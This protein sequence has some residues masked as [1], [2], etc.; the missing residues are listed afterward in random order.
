V[1]SLGRIYSCGYSGAQ[2]V[3]G[4]NS[5]TNL[6]TPRLMTESDGTTPLTGV[7]SMAV[8]TA[9]APIGAVTSGGKLLR[10]G[11]GTDGAHGN[12]NTTAMAWPDYLETA[13]GSGVDRTDI[14]QAVV[15]GASVSSTR[16]VMWIRTTAG[17]IEVSG[18]RFL[19]NGDGAALSSGASNTF[20]L[21][22]G[23]IAAL[24]VSALYAGGGDG[25]V[26][27]AVTSGGVP[28]I[29]GYMSGNGL[30]GTTNLNVFSAMT[31]LPTGFSGAFTRAV[32]A[33]G[34]SYVAVILEATISG[35]KALA[36]I[37]YDVYYNTA[38][39]TAGVA[40]ASQTWGLVRGVRATI[41]AWQVFGTAQEYGLAVLLTDGELR[42]AGPSDQGQSGVTWGQVTAIDTLQPVRLGLPRVLKPPT[43]PGVYSSIT[44][45][46]YNDEVTNQ[47]STWRYVA[48]TA[49][50]GNAPPT[51]PTESN[52]YWQLIARKGDAG[53]ANIVFDF[54]G[55]T[56]VLAPGMKCRIP[57]S[58]DATIL[59]A[60]LVSDAVGSIVLDV[61]KDTYANYPP[62]VA[63][64]ITAAAK[65]TLSS[66]QKTTDSSLMGWTTT[67]AAGD[68]LI[69]NV[70][71]V[72]GITNAVL[73]LKVQR[74][75]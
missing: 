38:K 18:S 26:C 19:G 62:T 61:W 74:T 35:A 63:D 23:A 10:W 60:T 71:S 32:I 9:Y 34:S 33:G 72:T 41:S 44:S 25:Y 24:T 42:A 70:D 54:D 47:G 58:F 27:I 68:I 55:G 15:A 52:S 3:M 20:Q 4:Y 29:A 53:Y 11:A 6:T 67:I 28:Y 5:T 39:G 22:S 43:F 49:S 45:Y 73:T 37:G 7:T 75:T 48:A 69:A 1:T 21:A 12:N 2:H 56:S 13:P 46:S 40:A 64:T 14:A 65:P 57:V 66:A 51:L 17:K 31:G 8:D 50:A 16:A 59:S 36:S 30:Q